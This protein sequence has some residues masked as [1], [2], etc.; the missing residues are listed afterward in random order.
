MSKGRHRREIQ[1]KRA[2][3][4]AAVLGATI[5]LPT[6]VATTQASAASVS[7]WDIVAKCESSNNWHINTGNG[8]YGGLQFTQ[9]TWAAYGGLKYASRADLATKAEQINIAEKVLASQGPGAWPVCS[10]KAG[11]SKGG[12]APKLSIT[13]STPKVTTKSAPSHTATTTKAL[14]AVSYATAQLGK[15]YVYGK[16]GPNSFDCSGLTYA[17][18][19]HAGVNIPRT[20]EGQLHGLHHVSKPA[21]GDIVVSRGGDH[22]AL[23]VGGGYVIDAPNSRSV[24]RKITLAKYDSW[25]N[26]VAYVRPAGGGTTVVSP[27]KGSSVHKTEPKVEVKEAPEKHKHESTSGSKYTV[28]SGDTLSGIA[29]DKDVKGGWHTLYDMNKKVVGSDPNLIFP[30][31]VLTIPGTATV[32]E[33]SVKTTKPAE[34]PKVE[35]KA[36][37][38]AQSTNSDWVKPV[39]GGIGTGY[40]V[41][42]GSWSSGHHTGVDFHATSGTPVKAVHTG[43][44]VKAGWGGAYGNEIIIKH[45]PGVYT[46][47]GHLSSIHVKVGEKVTT[48][49]MIGLSGAT[50]NA[51]GPHLHF[52]VRVGIAYGTDVDPIGFLESKGLHL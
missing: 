10:L 9:S 26:V 33:S 44:V 41:A 14:K 28:V 38:V 47:Y 46:Q 17:A 13:K 8:F 3:A 7:T 16:T 18:W 5:T 40:K 19:R 15:P 4:T 39:P 12:P 20:S 45:G 48:G 31:Q 2:L 50:G 23:Y 34:E 25:N 49:R 51:T 22:V 32:T 52:E 43:T 27:P 37:D 42:G 29:K 21:P 35:L 36:K 24:V 11:L 6:I 30:K 1:R